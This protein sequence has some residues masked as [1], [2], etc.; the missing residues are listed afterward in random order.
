MGDA[1]FSASETALLNRQLN[2]WETSVFRVHIWWDAHHFS[3]YGCPLL[4]LAVE[5]PFAVQ[6][7]DIDTEQSTDLVRSDAYDSDHILAKRQ[8]P[9]FPQDGN[10]EMVARFLDHVQDEA[11]QAAEL[12][13]LNTEQQQLRWQPLVAQTHPAYAATIQLAKR[14]Y[15]SRLARVFA[16]RL[17]KRQ[18]LHYQGNK[19]M[20]KQQLGTY[21]SGDPYPPSADF[22]YTFR[23]V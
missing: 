22:K 4:A 13:M 18:L 1:A 11:R 12:V 23:T 6:S 8:L 14:R 17:L 20:D 3:H 10:P 5:I 2:R 19:P 7:E 15:Y 16:K 21:A 9:Y